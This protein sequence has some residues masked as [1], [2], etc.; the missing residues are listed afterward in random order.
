MISLLRA[1]SRMPR[2]M[3]CN[4]A[5][6][7]SP[8]PS[9]RMRSKCSATSSARKRSSMPLAPK[10]RWSSA[11]AAT[12]SVNPTSCRYSWVS[13]VSNASTPSSSTALSRHSRIA[14]W[15]AS[16]SVSSRVAPS[17]APPPPPRAA[18]LPAKRRRRGPP[19]AP[20]SKPNIEVWMLSKSKGSASA[21]SP[22]LA[23]LPL[24]LHLAGPRTSTPPS[25]RGRYRSPTFNHPSP[26]SVPLTV[27]PHKT[28]PYA[29]SSGCLVQR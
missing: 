22:A 5:S 7:A 8:G 9:A 14:S 26:S 6:N 1:G 23:R 18:L 15:M 12:R 19:S 17:A 11:V 13:D 29:M 10:S 4:L 2:P 24:L 28:P 25:T 16:K 27:E 20:S 3:F 21:A